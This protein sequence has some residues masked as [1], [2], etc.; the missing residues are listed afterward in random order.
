MRHRRHFGNVVILPTGEFFAVGGQDTTTTYCLIPELFEEG[1]NQWVDMATHT[2]PRGYHS[3]AILLPDGRVLVCGGEGCSVDY[4]IWEP[5]YFNSDWGGQRPQGVAV[6]DVTT[7]ATVSQINIAGLA[8]G[9]NCRASWVNA[10]QEG[11]VV[12]RVVLMRPEA[13]THHDDGGQRMVRLVAWDDGEVLN[14][15]AGSIVFNSPASDLHAPR[16]WWM[17]F[18]VTST[19]VPSMAYWVNLG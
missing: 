3:A 5:P 2:S 19:G 18:L 14:G 1:T 10:M 12:D 7:G 17:M 11:V 8:Y 9:Q 16:G 4:Q 13:L 6:T 15:A